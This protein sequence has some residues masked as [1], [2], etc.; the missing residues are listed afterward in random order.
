MLAEQFG[1]QS[2]QCHEEL[3]ESTDGVSFAIA[4][5]G[6][7]EMATQALRISTN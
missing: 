1:V 2:F 3:L 7:A 4:P 5:V 6:Q